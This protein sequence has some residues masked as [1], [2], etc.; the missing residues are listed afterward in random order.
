MNN[1]KPEL[2]CLNCDKSE[3]ETPLLQLHYIQEHQFICPQ[4]LPVLIHT[5]DKLTGKLK[6]AEQLKPIQKHT[7]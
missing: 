3:L 6:N 1:A 4:C 5:P 7:R 2:H